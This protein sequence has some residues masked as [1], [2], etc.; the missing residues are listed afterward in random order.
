[1]RTDPTEQRN[2]ADRN[3]R[4]VR[5]LETLLA[6]HN[7]EQAPPAWPSFIQVPVSIDKTLADTQSPDDEFVYWPN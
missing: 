4:K 3:A 2:L 6:A 5:E 7:A 1:M